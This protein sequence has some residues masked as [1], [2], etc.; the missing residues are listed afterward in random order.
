MS[1]VLYFCLDMAQHVLVI[2]YLT[3]LGNKIEGDINK[4][5]ILNNLCLID[6]GLPK[7]EMEKKSVEI[8]IG[9][10]GK[11]SAASFKLYNILEFSQS[12]FQISIL[13]F[14]GAM[15][16][17]VSAAPIATIMGVLG[18]IGTFLGMSKK[19]SNEQEA[20]VLLAIYRLG[21]MCHISTIQKE[22]E[23]SFGS[24]INEEQ[25]QASLKILAKYRTIEIKENEV[26]IIETVN[27]H[28]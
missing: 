8:S 18:L 13:N 24:T 17:F 9:S 12:E 27:I 15:G 2:K 6:S 28:R 23:T 14:I 22:Y 3:E 19:E 10:D 5:I 11:V 25:L 21:K 20:K 26:L 1:T 7:S 16:G 4:I